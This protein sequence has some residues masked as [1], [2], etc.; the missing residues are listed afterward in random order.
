M[1][2]YAF[3][4]LTLWGATTTPTNAS[5]DFTENTLCQD[6]DYIA[7]RALYLNTN[8]DNWADRTGWPNAAFF[9]A[10][11]TRP[12]GTELSTW[13]GLTTDFNGC[14]IELVLFAN[15]LNGI[16]PPEL[17]SMTNLTTLHLHSNN[18]TGTIPSE[19]GNLMNLES[20]RLN[21]NQL[22]GSIPSEFANLTNLEELTLYNN[23][24]SGCYDQNLTNLC[25]QLNALYSS[26]NAI[27][28]SN[29]FDATWEDFCNNGT[30]LCICPTSLDVSGIIS[31]DTYQASNN[32][33]SDG[34]VSAGNNVQFRAGQRVL[35]SNDFKVESNT[36]FSVEIGDCQ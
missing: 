13:F 19:L 27:S 32:I 11:P 29:S 18:L 20:L 17:G 24:L 14:V 23:Q 1:I 28:N 8:G 6:D 25:T 36:N 7:L 21:T 2:V 26:N 3:T 22:S 4:L 16:I 5:N 12:F 34:T 31:S 35:L 15:D 9:N 30:G 33:S 10:N